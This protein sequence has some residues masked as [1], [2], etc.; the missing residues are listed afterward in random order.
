[1]CAKLMP[2]ALFATSCFCQDQPPVT[3]ERRSDLAINVNWLH[4]SYVRKDVPLKPLGGRQRFRLYVRQTY[5]TWGIY[6]K[7][8]AFA[9]HDQNPQH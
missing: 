9:L 5:T 8:T 6:I 4:G 7:T 3:P 2:L 1:M